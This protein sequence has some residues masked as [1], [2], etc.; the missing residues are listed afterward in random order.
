MLEVRRTDVFVD[1]LKALRD[2]RAKARI[3]IRLKRVE[4][5]SLGDVK[6]VGDGVSELRFTFGPGYRVYFT[7]VGEAVVLLLCGGDKD[8]QE[9]DIAAAKEMAKEIE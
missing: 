9:R 4:E 2:R 5:G 7:R 8:S 3:E 6:S 1:W